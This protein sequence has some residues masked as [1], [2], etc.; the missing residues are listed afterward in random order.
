MGLVGEPAVRSL[1]VEELGDF[2][3]SI[4]TLS[5]STKD[6][7]I[8]DLCFATI[9]Q[10]WATIGKNI[11]VQIRHYIV[12]IVL[13]LRVALSPTLKLREEITLK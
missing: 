7:D 11:Y 8:L 2:I 9:G 13:Q 6:M 4:L 10:N 3:S 5:E 12:D 1:L